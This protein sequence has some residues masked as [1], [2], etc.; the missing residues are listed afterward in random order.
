MYWDTSVLCGFNIAFFPRLQ[1]WSF[2]CW[3]SSF[4]RLRCIGLDRKVVERAFTGRVA[5]D[6]MGRSRATRVFSQFPRDLRL[7]FSFGSLQQ[8]LKR[9]IRSPEFC[10][11]A[12]VGK[13]LSWLGITLPFV[14]SGTP[15]TCEALSFTDIA[16]ESMMCH[17][18]KWLSVK[19]HVLFLVYQ[20]RGK[21]QHISQWGLCMMCQK[22]PPNMLLMDKIRQANCGSVRQRYS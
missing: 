2:V 16:N 19:R 13:P 15:S 10:P 11:F 6:P 12:S 3:S 20:K 5:D 14:V 4:R 17:G 21:G 9:W 22:L 18:G 7:I 8:W 1:P